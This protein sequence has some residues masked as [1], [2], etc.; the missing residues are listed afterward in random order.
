MMKQR[1]VR[2]GCILALAMLGAVPAAQ[3]RVNVHVGIG[4]PGV[5][6]APPPPLVVA[7]PSPFWA[8]P[9]MYSRHAFPAWHH[10][11]HFGPRRGPPPRHHRW[12]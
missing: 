5:M 10:P 3:A 11:H 6:F 12:R 2:S 9:V 8:P 1:L 7:H 4:F